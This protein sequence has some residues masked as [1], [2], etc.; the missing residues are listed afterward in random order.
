MESKEAAVTCDG[1]LLH[2]RQETLSRRQWTD[3]YYVEP[4]EAERSRRLASVSAG[5]RNRSVAFWWLGGGS[6]H[7][8][9]A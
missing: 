5:R 9:Q 4:H 8:A 3:E 1:I 6:R 7:V 2:R